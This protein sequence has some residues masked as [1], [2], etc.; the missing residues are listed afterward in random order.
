M[1]VGIAAKRLSPLAEAAATGLLTVLTRCQTAC[2]VTRKGTP[3][4]DS[5]VPTASDCDTVGV[6]AFLVRFAASA[7]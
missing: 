2:V 3:D 1:T 4:A 7:F 6:V 5:V